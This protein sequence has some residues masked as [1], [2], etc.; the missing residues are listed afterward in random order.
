MKDVDSKLPAVR[1]IAWLGLSVDEA[2]GFTSGEISAAATRT[3]FLVPAARRRSLMTRTSVDRDRAAMAN[4]FGRC[5]VPIPRN[6]GE[7][8]SRAKGGETGSSYAALN[9][10]ASEA[11]MSTPE[12]HLGACIS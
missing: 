11:A 7:V 4:R 9:V 1:S 6:E 5:F 12:R 8:P 3:L 10:L 2:T